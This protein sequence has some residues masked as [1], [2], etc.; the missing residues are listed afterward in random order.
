VPDDALDPYEVLQVHPTAEHEVI[1][2]AYRTLARRYH[3]D[4]SSSEESRR[5]M[6][7]INRAWEALGDPT[8]RAEVDR[9]RGVPGSGGSRASAGPT[10]STAGSAPARQE[11]RRPSAATSP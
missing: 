10:A 9:L 2:A 7:A 4:M 6:V 3:P 1:K 11:P 8:R 5:R